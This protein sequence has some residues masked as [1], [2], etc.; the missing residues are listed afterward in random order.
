MI[1]YHLH[2][3]ANGAREEQRRRVGGGEERNVCGDRLPKPLYGLDP[4][5]LRVQTGMREADDLL[6][7]ALR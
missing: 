7:V 6:P 5:R 4:E 1:D 3:V 2:V